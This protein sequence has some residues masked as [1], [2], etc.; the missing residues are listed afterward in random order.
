MSVCFSHLLPLPFF[1]PYLHTQA[2]MHKRPHTCW[3]TQGP[4]NSH[5]TT[6]LT[7]PTGQ[8]DCA[9]L[10]RDTVLKG[11]D[12]GQVSCA[13]CPS[14]NTDSVPVTPSCWLRTA[15]VHALASLPRT[16]MQACRVGVDAQHQQKEDLGPQDSPLLP[17]PQPWDLGTQSQTS[18]Q[19]LQHP[20]FL[21][22]LVAASEPPHLAQV[23]PFSSLP[24]PCG[25]QG[26]SWQ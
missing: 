18:L 5:P 12:A 8:L 24:L 26:P 23:G 3:L 16:S 15:F 13:S 22:P 20:H 25:S 7:H 14:L 9:T 4:T 21:S 19:P 10:Q 2:H 11:E 1:L 17:P 6:P